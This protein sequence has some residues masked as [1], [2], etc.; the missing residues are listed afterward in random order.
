MPRSR[1]DDDDYSREL[2]RDPGVRRRKPLKDSEN[3]TVKILLILGAIFLSILLVCGGVI[4][5]VAYLMH[6]SYENT[7]EWASAESQRMQGEMAAQQ[8][9]MQ[10]E[11][12]ARQ[13]QFEEE[14][15]KRQE[16]LPTS[17]RAKAQSFVRSWVKQVHEKRLDDAYAL[18]SAAYQRR[19]SRQEFDRFAARNPNIGLFPPN[20]GFDQGPLQGAQF[21]FSWTGHASRGFTNY[22]VTVIKVGGVWLIDDIT[23]G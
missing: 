14:T 11:A 6:R 2:E 21:T 4:A 9:K 20:F 5:Y 17:D 12:L 8:Q 13:R 1:S 19:V 10:E 7:M 16:A 15:R 3:S 23:D 22:T 18:T